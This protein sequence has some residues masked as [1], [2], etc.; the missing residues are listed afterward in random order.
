MLCLQITLQLAL[1]PS[2][3]KST[4]S[5]ELSRASPS[6]QSGATVAQR[7]SWRA[8]SENETVFTDEAKQL[9]TSLDVARPQVG[10]RILCFVFTYHK[11]HHVAAIVKRTWG[12]RCDHL[13]FVSDRDDDELGASR[14]PA[15]GPV[16]H[17]HTDCGIKMQA[18]I[19]KLSLELLDEFDWF[20]RADEDT[21]VIVENLRAFLSSPTVTRFDPHQ[22]P[23]F[24][25]HTFRPFPEVPN[26][27]YTS[28]GSGTAFSRAAVALLYKTR[29]EWD[30]D[31][32]DDL[33]V[34]R[35]LSQHGV[36]PL[37][38]HDIQGRNRFHVFNPNTVAR[39]HFY[40]LDSWLHVYD[41]TV[42][43]AAGIANC[44]NPNSITFHYMTPEMIIAADHMLY[45]CRKDTSA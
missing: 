7:R 43:K 2:V 17:S 45:T 29:H 10:P 27:R 44:C 18:A 23:L 3:S 11:K 39:V 1:Y 19:S 15:D 28:G 32:V 22:V 16:N 12:G 14:L 35:A 6:H 34:G 33:A 30:D 41:A 8:C 4:T 9:L 5:L 20:F 40:P 31:P 13:L 21:Y 38:S 25:G 26:L 24:V 36:A 37:I 42:A